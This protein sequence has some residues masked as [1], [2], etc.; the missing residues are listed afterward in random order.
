M[1]DRSSLAV[2]QAVRF[3]AGLFER[4]GLSP[5]AAAEMGRAL[6]D[7]DVAG[8]PSHGLSQAEVGFSD[9]VFC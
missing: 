4:A 8:L 5:A 7:A 1:S 6:V 9:R 2:G 3:I